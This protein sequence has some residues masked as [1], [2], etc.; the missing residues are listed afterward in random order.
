MY[1]ITSDCR[2]SS[3]LFFSVRCGIYFGQ[4]RIELWKEAFQCNALD[5]LRDMK[6]ITA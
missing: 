2:K 6:Q 1:C 3:K 4:G 5:I